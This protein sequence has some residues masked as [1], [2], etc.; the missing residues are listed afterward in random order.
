MCDYVLSVLA[1]TFKT[2]RS[3]LCIDI[4]AG[5]GLTSITLTKILQ[6]QYTFNHNI[7]VVATDYTDSI[8]CNLES[9][10]RMNACSSNCNT[11]TMMEDLLLSEVK[12]LD[13]FD[14]EDHRYGISGIDRFNWDICAYV[15]SAEEFY[16]LAR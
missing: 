3:T 1:C 9:N 14:T 6:E 5:T 16:I 12:I 7:K 11:G 15:A 4:G 13:L 8:L 2:N 10:L